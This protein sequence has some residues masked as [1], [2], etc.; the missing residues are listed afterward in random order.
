MEREFEDEDEL[1][2]F[3]PDVLAGT[4]AQAELVERP[5]T[6][7]SIAAERKGTVRNPQIAMPSKPCCKSS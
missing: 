4:W 1:L 6:T 3:L 2:E 5:A 7:N